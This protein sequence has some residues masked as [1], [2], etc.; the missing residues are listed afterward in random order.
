MHIEAD[1]LRPAQ[2]ACIAQKQD[3]PVSEPAEIVGQGGHHC[4]D[5]L[6]QDR[7][8]LNR[9]A[10]MLAFDPGQHRGDVAV[11]AIKSE[12]ALPVV[13]AKP[14]ETTLNRGDRKGRGLPRWR[15]QI[16]HI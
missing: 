4:L 5:V 15:S 11:L 6:R 7:F 10:R 2:A 16:S 3:R 14:R 1:H 13:P 9:R 8:L 12:P